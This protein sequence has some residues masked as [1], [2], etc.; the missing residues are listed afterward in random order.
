RFLPAG[1]SYGLQQLPAEH[2]GRVTVLLQLRREASGD[3][4]AEYGR[5]NRRAEKADEIEHRQET[6]WCMRRCGRLFGYGPDF[7]SG[8]LAAGSF[9]RRNGHLAVRDLV[10]GAAAG[11]PPGVCGPDFAGAAFA[12]TPALMGFG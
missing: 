5:G 10:A 9:L 1:G 8:V 11:A 4:R 2:R 12:P 6:R 3:R 7:G